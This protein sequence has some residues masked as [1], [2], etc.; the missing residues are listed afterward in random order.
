M[1]NYKLIYPLL[2]L[3]LLPLS[4]CEHEY[5]DLPPT[6]GYTA[7]SFQV[8]S[9]SVSTE[10]RSTAA[11][12][13]GTAVTVYAYEVTTEGTNQTES[14]HCTLSKQYTTDASGTL[15]PDDGQ[16]MALLSGLTYRFYAVSPLHSFASGSEKQFELE[17][18]YTADFKVSSLKETLSSSTANISFTPFRLEYSAIRVAFQRDPESTSVSSITPDTSE[19]GLSLT[20]LS[21]TPYVYTLGD[22]GIDASSWE[23][24]GML[25]IP[26]DLFT[27]V[28]SNV[29]Y[30][31]GGYL[32]PKKSA[33]FHI[34]AYLTANG[35]TPVTFSATVPA[36]AFLPGKKYVF[37]VLFTDPMVYLTLKV[38]DWDGVETSGDL[39]GDEGIGV[40]VGDWSTDGWDSGKIGSGDQ[41]NTFLV[42]SW[43]VSPDAWNTGL[44]EGGGDNGL[45]IGNWD[46]K[47]W[48]TGDIGSGDSPNTV[49]G[50]GWNTGVSWNSPDTGKSQGDNTVTGNGWN[51]GNWNTG[52]IGSGTSSGDSPNTVTGIGWNT[53]GSWNNPDTG[54]GQGDNTVTGNGWNPGSWNT[55]G[56]GS[57]DHPNPTT[58]TPWDNRTNNMGGMGGN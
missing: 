1:N 31:I 44:G 28:T 42:N 4:S 7:V 46:P 48:N 43:A 52:G 27:E 36:M 41:P 38:T 56:I 51:S 14:D 22:T 57:G 24:D 9:L 6:A 40:T 54:K 47:D 23:V 11:L 21:H 45:Q 19:S 10:T 25:N 18:S 39:G 26:V 5:D 30:T 2:L 8:P 29:L 37:T 17:N 58:T 35:S 33:P 13:E 55:G 50:S 15:V 49:T 12:V 34:T 20:A 16:P 53:G 3:L 32:L